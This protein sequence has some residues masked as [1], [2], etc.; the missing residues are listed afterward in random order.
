MRE[1]EI[2]SLTPDIP[3]Y[4]NARHFLRVIDDTPYGLYRRTVSVIQGQRGGQGERVD[5]TDPDA[6]ISER[7]S[8]E[9]QGLARRIWRGSKQALNPRYLRGCW[10]LTTKHALVRKERDVLRVSER[11][12]QFVIEPEGSVVAEID[13]YE[14]ILTTLRLVA[15][16]GP[17][18]CSELLPGYV[19]Y[20]R[21]FTS[22]RSEKVIK[23]SLDDRVIN[24][25]DRR[26]VERRA[27]TYQV[28]AAG[29]VYLERYA[30]LIPGRDVKHGDL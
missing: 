13:G 20:C 17:G 16:R 30:G 7:L 3:V 28:T 10:Y 23:R 27:Q 22:H 2:R 8:G 21:A 26:Y 4:P 1:Q 24:L 25:V 15:E 5:W 11:G 6:W 18:R 19:D 29:R 9:E 14:G 12:Q